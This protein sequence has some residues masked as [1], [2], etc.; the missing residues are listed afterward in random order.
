MEDEEWEDVLVCAFVP[1]E[2]KNFTGR[3]SI[4]QMLSNLEKLEIVVVQADAAN[5]G[6]VEDDG[7]SKSGDASPRSQSSPDQQTEDDSTIPETDTTIS[8]LF[9]L[10]TQETLP[11]EKRDL[12]YLNAGTL[13]GKLIYT[14]GLEKSAVIYEA[15]KPYRLLKHFKDLGANVDY[16]TA[17]NNKLYLFIYQKPVRIY[18]SN[19]ELEAEVT[20]NFYSPAFAH[21]VIATETH[22]YYLCKSKDPLQQGVAIIDK[23]HKTQM[24][25][26]DTVSV[27]DFSP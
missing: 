2:N 25:K 7:D 12:V 23:L 10:L 4:A 27:A 16:I 8:D 19:F 22:L 15:S 9:S 20:P 26:I 18:S 5:L 11:G 21:H 24:F 14:L 13:N 6:K 17:W 3:I 1:L